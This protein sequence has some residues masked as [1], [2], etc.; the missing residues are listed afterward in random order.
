MAHPVSCMQQSCQNKSI[1]KNKSTSNSQKTLVFFEEKY[2]L[3][4]MQRKCWR[5]WDED[6]SKK[7]LT[8]QMSNFFQ[9]LCFSLEKK[10]M[11]M[12]FTH[13]VYDKVSLI[14]SW[15]CRKLKNSLKRYSR[16][17]YCNIR[18]LR[19]SD[20]NCNSKIQLCLKTSQKSTRKIRHSSQFLIAKK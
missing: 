1:K 11:I 8:S 18:R 5:Y 9:I 14:W 2:Q 19:S 13:K 20:R 17:V 16:F 7:V 10:I 15:S 4:W 3:F 6:M 12:A